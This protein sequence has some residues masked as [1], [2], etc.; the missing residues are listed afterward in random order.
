MDL[1]SFLN[2]EFSFIGAFVQFRRVPLPGDKYLEA[3]ALDLGL[4]PRDLDVARNCP[5][6]AIVPIEN[7][8]ICSARVSL[9]PP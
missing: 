6:V 4:L 2:E 3:E 1:I 8:V 7:S 9:F 5:E